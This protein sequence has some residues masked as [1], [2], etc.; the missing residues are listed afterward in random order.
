MWLNSGMQR[1]EPS[2][3]KALS[4]FK[5]VREYEALTDVQRAM[6]EVQVLQED[7][8]YVTLKRLINKAT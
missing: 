6:L 3:N 2:L 8:F 4:M 7:P 1:N 5:V